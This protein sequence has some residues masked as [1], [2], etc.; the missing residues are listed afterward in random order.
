MTS[1]KMLLLSRQGQDPSVV[2][3]SEHK[4]VIDESRQLYLLL[5]FR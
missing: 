3:P 1:I 4:V 2:D 5:A